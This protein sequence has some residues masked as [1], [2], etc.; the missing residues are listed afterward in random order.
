[1]VDSENYNSTV[2]AIED[3][4]HKSSHPTPMQAA[5]YMQVKTDPDE[6]SDG[7]GNLQSW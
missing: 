6:L 5:P 2:Y 3:S 7:P 1:M 4:E